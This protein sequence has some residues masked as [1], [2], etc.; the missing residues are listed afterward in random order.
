MRWPASTGSGWLAAGVTTARGCK[1]QVQAG[2]PVAQA[3]NAHGSA[4]VRFVPQSDLPPGKA[5]EQF[6]FERGSVPTRDNLHDFFNGLCWMRFPAD[7]EAAQPAAGG[8]N[9]RGGVRRRARPGARRA[10][11]V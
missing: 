11:G 9:C 3:L 6:I 10:D 1:R 2:V 5:Y 8:R 4:P 7:Q